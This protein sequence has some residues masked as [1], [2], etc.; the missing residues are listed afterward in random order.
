[1]DAEIARGEGGFAGD[2][3]RGVVGSGIEVVVIRKLAAAFGDDVGEG[4]K[5]VV[6]L[7]GGDEA[8]GGKEHNKHSKEG[9]GADADE[10]S[11]QVIDHDAVSSRM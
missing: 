6:G 9:E 1:M 7:Q 11:A 5:G 3:V 2:A 10:A 8:H 4:V